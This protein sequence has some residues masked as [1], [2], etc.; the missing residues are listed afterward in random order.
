MELL[1][2][3][4]DTWFYTVFTLKQVLWEASWMLCLMGALGGSQRIGHSALLS[5]SALTTAARLPLLAGAID[6]FPALLPRPPFRL[7]PLGLGWL[8]CLSATEIIHF[9]TSLLM[10]S[11]SLISKFQPW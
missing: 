6:G 8:H 2:S 5:A 9:M 11:C 3:R 7:S 4:A 1:V 10:E